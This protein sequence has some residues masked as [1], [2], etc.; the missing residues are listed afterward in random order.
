MYNLAASA[1]VGHLPRVS[2]REAERHDNLSLNCHPQSGTVKDGSEGSSDCG[3]GS[4]VKQHAEE[5]QPF[6]RKEGHVWAESFVVIIFSSCISVLAA[7]VFGTSL[8]R[9]IS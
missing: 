5:A 6:L 7:I 1:W 4:S 2:L 9:K 3:L 8:T